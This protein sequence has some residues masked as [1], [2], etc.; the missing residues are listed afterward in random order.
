MEHS[1]VF[2][3][4]GLTTPLALVRLE[5][6]GSIVKTVALHHVILR[7]KA[8]IDQFSIGLKVLGVLDAIQ[9]NRQ[10]FQKYFCLDG[11]EHMT[12]GA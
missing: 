5:D 7:T 9:K 4:S 1:S 8:E 10:L 11:A 12:S 2:I 6:K 3:E